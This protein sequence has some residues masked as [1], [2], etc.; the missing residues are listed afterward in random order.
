MFTF[1]PITLAK[2]VQNAVADFK[3]ESLSPA[4]FGRIET[5]N[6]AVGSAAGV[7]NKVTALK[8]D[9]DQ[10]IEVGSQ[11]KMMTATLI[12]QLAGEGKINIDDLA[13]KY[14]HASTLQ[15]IAAADTATVRQL[16]QMT[17][18]IANYTDVQTP[19]AALPLFAEKLLDNPDVAF[20]TDDALE[21]VRGQPA[22]AAQGTLS[23]SNTNYL[24]LGKIIEGI[25]GKPLAETFETRIFQPAGMTHSDLAQATAP[26][27]LV[28][29]YRDINGSKQDVTDL[30]WDK[31]AEGGVVS[32]T[33]DM[34]KFLKALCV[35]GKLLPAAQLAEMKT[36]MIANDTPEVKAGFG[37]GLT[38]YDIAG[39]GTFYGFTGETFGFTTAT[40]LSEKSGDTASFAVNLAGSGSDIE[41]SV[42]DL[43]NSIKST[44]GWKPITSFDAKTDVMKIAAADA[45]SAHVSGGTEFK[46]AFGDVSLK[47]PLRLASVTTKNIVF[48]DSSVLVVGDNKVGTAGDDT[49]NA[50][51]IAKDFSKAIAMDNQLIGLGG[52][53]RLAGGSG[54]DR[55]IGGEGNDV[56]NGRDGRDTLR[57]G[58]G[59]DVMWGGDDGDRFVFTSIIDSGTTKSSRDLIRDFDE[60]EDRISLYSIDANTS[61]EGNQD[62][63]FLG[64]KAFDGK[65]AA[66]HFVKQGGN[67]IIEGDVNGD[68]RADFQIELFG[69]HKPSAND[70]IL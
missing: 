7:A 21:I 37:L 20:T 50:I 16:L 3:K 13:S 67:T 2:P 46:A 64:N 18:G 69:L 15:G 45:A 59:R 47:L 30:K 66:L 4:S 53:D 61:L 44:P 10:R 26:S 38:K 58:T 62:F 54:N 36:T 28:R 29:G 49:A 57:G 42:L 24:L 6:Y 43:L 9:A 25:T 22:D 14:L 63:R 51:D 19:G 55:L 48:A 23:Y 11:T 56:L 52:N 68:G 40:F 32:T 17:S 31:Y 41:K 65:A 70:F 34:I 39:R 35:D 12:L 1:N 5:A 8:A 33:A 60:A 27:D